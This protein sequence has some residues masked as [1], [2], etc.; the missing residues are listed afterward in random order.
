[1]WSLVKDKTK[2]VTDAAQ[3]KVEEETPCTR[4][5]WWRSSRRTPAPFWRTQGRSWR[6]RGRPRS[7]SCRWWRGPWRRRWR[8]WRRRWRLKRR[9]GL[10]PRKTTPSEPIIC[11]T[12]EVK[13]LECSFLKY[14]VLVAACHLLLWFTLFRVPYT[15][16]KKA[17]S[18]LD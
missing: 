13:S 7:R 15:L 12:V 18:V 9:M 17:P 4:T 10:L 2:E 6:W 3:D 5:R 11:V 16:V 1:M 14:T 8:R